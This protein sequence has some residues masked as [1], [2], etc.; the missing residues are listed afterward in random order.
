MALEAEEAV[1]QRIITFFFQKGNCQEFAGTL[2]HLSRSGVQM[3]N[4]HPP[5]APFVS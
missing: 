4:M 1:T 3:E 5:V 2:G